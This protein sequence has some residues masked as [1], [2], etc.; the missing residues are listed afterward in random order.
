[1]TL[2]IAQLEAESLLVGTYQGYE[3]AKIGTNLYMSHIMFSLVLL[4]VLI[5]CLLLRLHCVMLYSLLCL[6]VMNT[7]SYN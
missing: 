6:G 2:S 5:L 1:V 7:I 3:D 4:F